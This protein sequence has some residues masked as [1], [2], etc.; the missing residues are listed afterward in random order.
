MT[1]ATSGERRAM[2]DIAA[3]EY[4]IDPSVDRGHTGELLCSQ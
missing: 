2:Q 1:G 3:A 4:T